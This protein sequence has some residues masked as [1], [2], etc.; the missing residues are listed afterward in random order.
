MGTI[1]DTTKKL[2]LAGKTREEKI[3]AL[4]AEYA[5]IQPEV[6]EVVRKFEVT[7]RYMAELG[8]PREQSWA[9][10]LVSSAEALSLDLDTAEG[11]GAAMLLAELQLRLT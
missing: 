8:M 5:E 1:K 7:N 9:A 6:A 3:A 2:D 4:A 11:M 10:M